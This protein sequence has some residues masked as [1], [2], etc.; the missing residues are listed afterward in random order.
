MLELGRQER[1][2]KRILSPLTQS[3]VTLANIPSHKSSR[4]F[5]LQYIL[6]HM[7]L[8]HYT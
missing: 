5:G 6:D 7:A 2:S 4:D 3:F 1:K 8:D